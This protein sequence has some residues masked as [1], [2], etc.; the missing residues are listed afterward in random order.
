MRPKQ[1]LILFVA[2]L[3]LTGCN[4][5]NKREL[6]VET[7][8]GVWQQEDYSALAAAGKTA[9][10]LFFTGD[11]RLFVETPTF[12]LDHAPS[13]NT[14]EYSYR[15]TNQELHWEEAGESGG[16]ASTIL[17]IRFEAGGMVLSV[18]KAGDKQ[19]ITLTKTSDEIPFGY[20]QANQD[21]I[22]STLQEQRD[23]IIA[24]AS[25]LSEKTGLP[26]KPGDAEDF[27]L[28]VFQGVPFLSGEARLHITP[29]KNAKQWGVDDHYVE[30]PTGA[31]YVTIPC[32]V[33]DGYAIVFDSYSDDEPPPE[34]R[35]ALARLDGGGGVFEPVSLFY[36]I[37]AARTDGATPLADFAAG[38]ENNFPESV[39]VLYQNVSGGSPYTV[40]DAE[41]IR[42]VFDALKNIT[43][44][45]EGGMAHTDDYLTYY[46]TYE[47]GGRMSFS[48]QSG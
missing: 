39:S 22:A 18:E 5:E 26:L 20:T 9:Y 21:G 13:H 25:R 34:W 17:D 28:S 2:A 10:K 36:F 32:Y 24:F 31:M 12:G 6:T 29:D 41:T 14:V 11:G 8:V 45:G 3:F 47:G 4:K 48:F 40:T 33:V 43:V 15:V 7:L 1:I 30:V 27:T 35:E 44:T 23:E 19:T 46:F 42:A 37:D 38:F 16:S